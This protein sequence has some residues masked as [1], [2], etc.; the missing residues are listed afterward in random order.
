M[1]YAR[2]YR[3]MSEDR[4][5]WIREQLGDLLEM[6]TAERFIGPRH[7]Q[8]D[9]GAYVSQSDRLVVVVARHGRLQGLVEG[10]WI[11]EPPPEQGAKT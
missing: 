1:S 4:A 7:G 3:P 8:P 9:A 6:A 10:C 5:Q 11:D 2:T